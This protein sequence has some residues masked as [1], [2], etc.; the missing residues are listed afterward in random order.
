MIPS[1][2]FLGL[3]L[4]PFFILSYSAQILL[5]VVI[6]MPTTPGSSG[7]AEGF[8]AGLYSV[9]I[10]SSLI[11]IFILIFRFITFHLNLIIGAIFQ[12]KIFK[13][14]SSFSLDEFR[15]GN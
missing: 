5:I 6:M 3:G 9:I 11:G 15:N 13:S 10:G 14:I 7:V 4:N 2:I 8:L 1:M 12:Y